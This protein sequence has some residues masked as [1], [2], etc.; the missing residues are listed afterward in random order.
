MNEE[1]QNR[2][3]R[4]GGKQAERDATIVRAPRARSKTRTTSLMDETQALDMT[5]LTESPSPDG[6]LLAGRY[7]LGAVL[8]RGATGVV[9]RGLDRVLRRDVAIKLLYADLAHEQETSARFQQEA[10][11]AARIHH[12]NAVAIFDTGVHEGQPFIVMEC[13]PGE[14]LASRITAHPLPFDEVHTIGAELLGA[15]DAAHQRGVIHRDIKP[16]NLLLTSE[17]SVKVADFGI[18]TDADRHALTSVGFVVGTLAYLAP[19]RLLGIPATARSDIYSAGVVLYEA[20]TGRKPFAGDTPAE[21]LNEIS[22]GSAIDIASLRPDIDPALT[23]VVMRAIQKDPEAR[24]ASAMAM[25]TA[26]D[27]SRASVPPTPSAP[28]LAA[29][30]VMPVPQPHDR[31]RRS[32][33]VII[34]VAAIVAGLGVG[35]FATRGGDLSIPSP[36]STAPTGGTDSHGAP[37]VST[38]VVTTTLR[39]STTRPPVTTAVRT[40]T[41]PKGKKDE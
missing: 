17:G 41:K 6:D 18:A 14:T 36:T 30:T 20:L 21:L 15:L 7:E 1:M 27:R 25:A 28:A 22:N 31:H 10:R 34:A 9:H 39:P 5:R 2:S 23:A 12:P 29:T 8:G 4:S 3:V 35:A 16:A 11:L 24:Y 40:T 13:L 26:L 19:E 33:S 32:R 37:I 38:T